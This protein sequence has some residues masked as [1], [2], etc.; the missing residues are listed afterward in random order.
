MP[1]TTLAKSLEEDTTTTRTGTL[2][3]LEE[4]TSLRK[5]KAFAAAYSCIS[6]LTSIIFFPVFRF[7]PGPVFGSAAAAFAVSFETLLLNT[8]DANKGGIAFFF[9]AVAFFFDAAALF[10]GAA[11]AAAFRSYFIHHTLPSSLSWLEESVLC[12]I[13]LHTLHL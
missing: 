10:F 3:W 2:L 9:G 4:A 11:V 13:F 5:G 12:I 8:G 1:R 6:L 7:A